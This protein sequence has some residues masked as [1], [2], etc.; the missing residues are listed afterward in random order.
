MNRE[1]AASNRDR[2]CKLARP[3]KPGNLCVEAPELLG[4]L[5]NHFA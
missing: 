5:S 3:I 2:L 1:R 4:I